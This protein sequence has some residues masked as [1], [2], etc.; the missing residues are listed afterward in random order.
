M[1]DVYVKRNSKKKYIWCNKRISKKLDTFY[2]RKKN[3]SK[4]KSI[5]IL[6]GNWVFL[7]HKP[8]EIELITTIKKERKANKRKKI[9]LLKAKSFEKKD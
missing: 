2:I 6:R 4:V 9:E 1:T 5:D 3:I 8:V 7:D